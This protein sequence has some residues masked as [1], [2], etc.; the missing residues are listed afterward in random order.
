MKYLKKWNHIFMLATVC[1]TLLFAPEISEES[2][3]N[4]AHKRIPATTFGF[5]QNIFAKNEFVAYAKFDQVSYTNGSLL[6]LV[7][8]F[9]YGLRDSL[10]LQVG[11]P[12]ILKS[13]TDSETQRG[14]GDLFA[15]LE[16]AF[17][18]K[19]TPQAQ[20]MAT[21]VGN[22]TFP[23]THLSHACDYS[24]TTTAHT[25][26][27]VGATAS[28]ATPRWY[29]Y[30]SSGATLFLKKDEKQPGTIILYEGGIGMNLGNPWGISTLGNIEANGVLTKKDTEHGQSDATTGSNLIFVGP[31]LSITGDRWS[32]SGGVQIPLYQR[33]NGMQSKTKFRS[34]L[35][36]NILF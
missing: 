13:K 10:S 8:S 4:F 6:Q 30:I 16:Y 20:T 23:T 35:I 24:I 25:N 15:T 5:G 26:F 18:S 33:L 1:N 34:T 11:L 28:H 29:G 3:G 2:T 17:F 19:T 12:L 36:I 21:V 14:I 9:V 31:T 27:F 7:P 22:V 32:I